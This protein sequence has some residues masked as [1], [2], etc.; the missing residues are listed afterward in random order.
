[1][2]TFRAIAK[3]IIVEWKKM[4]PYAEPY[5]AAMMR[6][7]TTDPHAC[8]FYDSAGEIVNRF[9]CNANTF[10]GE[11]ARRIKAELRSMVQ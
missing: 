3:E 11:S 7:D 6:L 10:R 5:V 1:M 4:S 2:R 8:Y 9:L